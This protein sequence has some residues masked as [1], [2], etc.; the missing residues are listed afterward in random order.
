[1]CEHI[2]EKMSMK[3]KKFIISRSEKTCFQILQNFTEFESDLAIVL[4]SF[5]FPYC[6]PDSND[7]RMK[8]SQLK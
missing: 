2:H 5:S 6:L 3:L 7:R 1:M 8:T 4:P